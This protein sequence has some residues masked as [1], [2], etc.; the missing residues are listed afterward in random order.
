MF[1]KDDSTGVWYETVKLI[2]SDGARYDRFGTSVSVSGNVALVGGYL[3]DD[4][5]GNSGSAYVFEIG[6]R[7]PNSRPLLTERLGMNLV[8]VYLPMVT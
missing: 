3:D 1:E 5:G 4:K 2:A 8:V 6:L 7:R